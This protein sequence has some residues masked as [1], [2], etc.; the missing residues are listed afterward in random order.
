MNWTW[1]T[2]K[3]Y[4][5]NFFFPDANNSNEP[6][7]TFL[8][9]LNHWI[10]WTRE[11]KLEKLHRREAH[12]SPNSID[13]RHPIKSK[14]TKRSSRLSRQSWVRMKITLQTNWTWW[15]GSAGRRNWN[16]TKKKRVEFS[17]KQR[18]PTICKVVTPSTGSKS[19]N[20]NSLSFIFDKLTRLLIIVSPQPASC[21]SHYWPN[22]QAINLI[23]KQ[24]K[25]QSQFVELINRPFYVFFSL[26]DCYVYLQA[27][28]FASKKKLSAFGLQPATFNYA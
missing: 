1:K 20:S 4:H 9:F 17:Q 15:D 6:M 3:I 2:W 14:H 23:F 19:H 25:G 28:W 21:S 22:N 26:F 27:K 13:Y 11:E 18:D 5:F 10:C 16:Y 24:R 8:M 7:K 12:F